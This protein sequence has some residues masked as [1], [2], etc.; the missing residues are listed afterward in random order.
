LL[1]LRL[2]S[3]AKRARS[4]Y[5]AEDCL[6][7][8]IGTS[9]ALVYGAG[10]IAILANSDK[11]GLDSDWEARSKAAIFLP[12]IAIVAV[13]LFGLWSAYLLIRFAIAFHIAARK[14]RRG[15]AGD[16]RAQSET[17]EKS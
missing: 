7:I 15:W 6:I 3:L 4:A 5:L 2:R 9:A 16:D 14:L 12:L 1:F 11:F 13:I 8:G 17:R 10:L